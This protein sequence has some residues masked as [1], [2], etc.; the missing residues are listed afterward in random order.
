MRRVSGFVWG[1]FGLAEVDL[2]AAVWFRVAVGSVTHVS[3]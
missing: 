2:Q 1:S 3:T